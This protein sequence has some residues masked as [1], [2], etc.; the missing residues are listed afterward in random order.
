M[1]EP[2]EAC[3]G[4][5]EVA[6]VF[7]LSSVERVENAEGAEAPDCPGI[8]WRTD[9]LHTILIVTEGRGSVLIA[10]QPGLASPGKLYF[11]GPGTW[12]EL[13]TERDSGLCLYRMAVRVERDGAGLFGGNGEALFEPLTRLDGAL[14]E[15]SAPAA[16]PSDALEALQRHIR[17]QQLMC[18]LLKLRHTAVRSGTDGRQAVEGTIAFMRRTYREDIS[19][20]QLAREAGMSRWQYG[21]IFK[22]LTGQTPMDY[23]TGL[24]M[25]RAKELMLDNGARVRDIAERVGFRDEYYFSRRFKQTTGLTPTAYRNGNHSRSPRIFSIQYLGE[26]LELGIRPVA[27]NSPMLGGLSDESSGVQGVDEPFDM[28]RI[29]PLK[30][31]MILFPSYVPSAV[32]EELRKVAPAVEISWYDDVYARMDA[33]GKM[34]GRR[35][36]AGD[37]IARYRSK[38]ERTRQRLREHVRAGET[39]AAFIYHNHDFYVFTGYQFGHTLYNGL[40]FAKPVR[41]E[42]L[43][44]RSKRIKW[45]RIEVG[46]LADYAGDRVFLALP[47]DG[48]DA[49]EGRAMLDHPAWRNLPAV[50][51]GRSYVVNDKWCLYDPITLEK[52][53]DEMVKW[54]AR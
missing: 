17:F 38:A 43:M 24:R 29:A 32:V 48:D 13:K 18:E 36:E 9:H 11:I 15:L 31:D 34:L 28:E 27:T 21:A 40:G 42:E 5:G 12:V 51:N 7:Y 39:A 54:L 8:G 33:L 44:R 25:D 50:R 53:L 26:L 2:D 4:A 19:V 46:E 47:D 30:P 52:H 45:K 41:I 35:K 1:K 23:L 16:D 10:G 49:V 3:P 22:S 20:G 14:Q 6:P 37:W